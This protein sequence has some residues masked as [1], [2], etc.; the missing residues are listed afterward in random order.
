MHPDP[1]TPRTPEKIFGIVTAGRTGGETF[2]ATQISAF[3][4]VFGGGGA[5]NRTPRRDGESTRIYG[6]GGEP[7]GTGEGALSRGF[8]SVD[9]EHDA[10]HTIDTAREYLSAGARG[11]ECGHLAMKLASAVLSRE[12]VRLALEVLAGG[13]FCHARATELASRVLGR[14]REDD[15]AVGE[16]TERVLR[17]A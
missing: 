12:D 7:T 8:R 1:G 5:G 17:G 16:V 15:D 2:L 9:A 13:P 3:F 11:D 14:Q 10:R 4:S 6:N